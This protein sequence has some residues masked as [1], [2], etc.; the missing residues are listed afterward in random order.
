M[1]AFL[2]GHVA[3]STL[4][5]KGVRLYE[6]AIHLFFDNHITLI[7]FHHS[8]FF[9]LGYAEIAVQLITDRLLGSIFLMVDGMSPCETDHIHGQK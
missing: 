8:E 6:G 4:C 9:Y 1:S 7:Y 3:A 2:W 5:Q